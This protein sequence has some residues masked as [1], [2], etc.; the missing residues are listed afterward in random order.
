MKPLI[1]ACVL[2]IFALFFSAGG[3]GNN[4]P[5]T[6]VNGRSLVEIAGSGDSNLFRITRDRYNGAI[7]DLPIGVFDSGIG[8]L[9]VL[10]EI[11]TV[12]EFDNATHARGADGR[13]DFEN[14]RFIYLG[15]QANMPYG[16]YPSE[17]KVGFLRE[18]IVKDA[19]FLL[20][21]RYWPTAASDAPLFDK[22]PVKAIV[23][24]C[25][26]ATAYGLEDVRA[27]LVT[28]GIPIYLVG[29]V[30]AGAKG[31]IE[32]LKERGSDGAVA[33]MATV[34]TCKSEGYP[35]A[36]EAVA[37]ENGVDIPD[38]TQQGSLGLA[39]AIEGDESFVVDSAKAGTV[40][41]RGPSTGNSAAPIDPALAESYGFET[42]GLLGDP[43]NP[44]SW[45]L[46]SVENYVRYDV[47]TL[48]DKHSRRQGAEPI[49]AVILGCTHFP[50]HV[51]R[52][53]ASFERMRNYTTPTGEHPYAASVAENMV[54]IDPSRIT[55]EQLFEALAI[56]GALL[57]NDESSAIPV[58]EFFIS[59]PNPALESAVIAQNGGFEYGYKYG[60]EPGNFTVEYVRRVPMNGDNLSSHVQ[61][62]IRE[63]MPEVWRRLVIFN[64]ESPRIRNLPESVRL[65]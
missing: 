65:R 38:V 13:P 48:V 21:E 53:A 1:S 54:F 39:G 14:E 4:A 63:T 52:I 28:W 49:T 33:V 59:V 16:N 41:Y 46:N 29:V 11:L 27:A 35:R 6:F 10:S 44:S 47:A 8:G 12:D 43:G 18:L 37:L 56:S 9:T 19:V 34:G 55:A 15:D 2:S 51:D 25:N 62:S 23:I 42:D 22:P 31:A 3:C 58:D 20:G 26:T 64:R 36:I 60:R 24:A 57:G 17:N 5:E 7:R 40:E 32:E 30:E 50:F 45:R 61:E